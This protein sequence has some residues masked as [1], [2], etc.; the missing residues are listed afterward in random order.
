MDY[1]TRARDLFDAVKDDN[2]EAQALLML[3]YAL[4]ADGK[5]AQ[6]LT[7]AGNALRLWSSAA[8]RS[9]VAHV[10]AALGAFAMTT[11]EFETAQCNYRLALPLFYEIGSKDDATI[12]NGMGWV[13]REMGDWQK[14]LN[15]TGVLKPRLRASETCSANSRRSRERVWRWLR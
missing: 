5:R 14:S 3:A 1:L 6:G 11:G 2:G 12:L 10:H 7:E 8:N 13:N 4:F 15:P 9:G